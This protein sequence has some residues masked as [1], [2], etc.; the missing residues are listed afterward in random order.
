MERPTGLAW[1][2]AGDEIWFTGSK[3]DEGGRLHAVTLS[4]RERVIFPLLGTAALFDI[5][6]DGRRVLL[7]R[8]TPRACGDG[9]YTWRTQRNTTS[10]G[11]TTPPQQIFRLMAKPFSS[12]SME[13]E[14]KGFKQPISERPTA[15]MP[16]GS[17]RGNL[18]R[19]RRMESGPWCCSRHHPHSWSCCPLGQASKNR[20]HVGPLVSIYLAGWFPD[21]RQ[22][23]F[24]G[25]EA[26]HRPRTYVQDIGGGEPRP[27]TAEG[28]EGDLLSPDGKLIAA[29]DRYGEF[30]LCPV[31]GGEPR[32]I[33]GLLEGDDHFASVECR[34]PIPFCTGGAGDLVLKIYK[35]DLASGRRELWK[36]L[37]PPDP[38]VLIGI[39]TTAG[40]VRLTPDGK[41]YVY[42]YWTYPSEL[43]LVEGLK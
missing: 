18:W 12:T 27:V 26:G 43:Y 35:L 17:A 8:G 29:H 15:L 30:Y 33:E 41:S 6:R 40:E 34:W 21:G 42:T 7:K 4:G 36:E 14:S 22:I 5:S 20:C 11:L 19:F 24:S 28:M 37:T 23:F 9:P 3:Q 31:E 38:A 2:G 13:R 10:P 25:T 16:C 1:S 32:A 39:G